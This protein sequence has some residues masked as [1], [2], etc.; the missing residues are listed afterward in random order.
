[1]YEY[2]SDDSNSLNN[3]NFNGVYNPNLGN[4][5]GQNIYYNPPHVANF[6]GQDVSKETEDSLRSKDVPN[7]L[8][9]RSEHDLFFDFNSDDYEKYQEVLEHGSVNHAI[10]KASLN[11]RRNSATGYDA[12]Q[13]QNECYEGTS[14]QFHE[15]N[16]VSTDSN[17]QKENNQENPKNIVQENQ[18]LNNEPV[19][20]IFWELFKE[21]FQQ[22][23]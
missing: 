17:D 14:T 19:D 23:P 6:M 12:I 21:E 4:I 7:D 9:G 8:D 20:S 22:N 10:D 13:P 15:C 18:D 11:S 3:D 1:M 2:V 5:E 16:H